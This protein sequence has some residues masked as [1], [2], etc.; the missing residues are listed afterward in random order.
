MQRCSTILCTLFLALALLLQGNF[1]STAA[2]TL[3]RTLEPVII[4]GSQ[5]EELSGVPIN[6][7][8]LFYT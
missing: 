1:N 8:F 7:L 3:T 5:L 2:S 6:E 4:D